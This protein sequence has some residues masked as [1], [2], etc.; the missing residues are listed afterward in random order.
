M[1]KESE[2]SG[3]IPKTGRILEF[4]NAE[5]IREDSVAARGV[6]CE[7]LS[8]KSLFNRETGTLIDSPNSALV[9]RHPQVHIV[10]CHHWP[11]ADLSFEFDM[12]PMKV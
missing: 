12:R 9:F 11:T 2:M 1:E 5:N 7:P 10:P 4:K 6:H 8:P 3:N